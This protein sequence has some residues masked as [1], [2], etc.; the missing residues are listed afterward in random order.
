MKDAA[1]TAIYG[2]R[3]ANG[4]VLITTKKGSRGSK[5][6]L[7]Y[8]SYV[9]MQEPWKYM[10]LLNAEEY[11]TLMNESRAAAGLSALPGL[12][13]PASLG[14]GTNWQ[15]AMFQS[16]PMANHSVLYTCLLYTSPSPRD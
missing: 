2:A 8:D 7:T 14:E 4:V 9:G 15:D 10:A 6:T 13:D 12:S 3:G 1:S 5:A 11:A 16:A